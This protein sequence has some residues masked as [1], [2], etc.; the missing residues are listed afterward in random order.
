MLW[1][2]WFGVMKMLAS[3]FAVPWHGEVHKAVA[4][5]PL[6]GEPD[7]TCAIP[8]TG[9]SIVFLECLE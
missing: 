6:E 2:G 5:V 3:L 4:V 7:V 9:Y 8:V 1:F